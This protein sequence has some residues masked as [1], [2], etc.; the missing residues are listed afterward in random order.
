MPRS[1]FHPLPPPSLRFDRSNLLHSNDCCLAKQRHTCLEY[2][3]INT[4]HSKFVVLPT[5]FTAPSLEPARLSNGLELVRRLLRRIFCALLVV[6]M[7][8]KWN[9]GY[10]PSQT[11]PPLLSSCKGAGGDRSGSERSP[12]F[13][14]CPDAGELAKNSHACAAICRE[15]EFSARQP[16]RSRG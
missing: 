2:P 6:V 7:H 5:R 1:T 9:S 15:C 3:A 4:W 14:V 12:P 10:K 16:P 11:N 8:I 13:G